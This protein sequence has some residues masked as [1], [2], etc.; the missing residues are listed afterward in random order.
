MIQFIY[1]VNIISARLVN[2][3]SFFYRYLLYCK[4]PL[5]YA[6]PIIS[7]KMGE[8]F[9]MQSIR[10]PTNH[11]KQ[12]RDPPLW[13]VSELYFHVISLMLQMCHSKQR[14]TA[15]DPNLLIKGCKA[16]CAAHS[17]L[18]ILHPLMHWQ[19]RPRTARPGCRQIWRANGHL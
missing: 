12:A 1:S 17:V 7:I 6:K 15:C 2:R 8:S 14:L 10:K 4:V 16:G 9:W 11:S 3:M 18:L 13:W 5:L 19:P